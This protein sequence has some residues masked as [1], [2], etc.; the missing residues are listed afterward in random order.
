MANPTFQVPLL[1]PPQSNLISVI[2][3]LYEKGVGYLGEAHMSLL[4]QCLPEGVTLEWV[5]Q[6]DAA[7]PDNKK[8]VEALDGG[9]MTIRYGINGRHCGQAVTRN[10]AFQ[11]SRGSYIYPLDQDDILAP[12]ALINLYSVFEAHKNVMWVTGKVERLFED[13]HT[14]ERIDPMIEPGLLSTG[15]IL[16]LF[17]QHGITT[18]FY[19]TATM[20]RRAPL[21]MVGG[22][23]AVVA[24]ED[25]E[26]QLVM[27]TLYDGWRI[28]DVV[29]R[30]R[31]WSGQAVLA[32]WYQGPDIEAIAT[33]HD[34]A[35]NIRNHLEK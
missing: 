35:R 23:P 27:G 8:L 12:N 2:T 30:R 22:W 32:D 3:P 1:D 6:E 13:G 33:R 28:D 5:I 19:P 14:E 10:M 24:A 4:G 34:R 21:H 15:Y 11:R 20:F 29:L 7:N 26:L 16:E 17:E 31:K 18:A 9:N 25:A